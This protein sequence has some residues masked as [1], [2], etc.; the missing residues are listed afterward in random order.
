VAVY[1]CGHGVAALAS[2]WWTC[3][4][5]LV[6]AMGCSLEHRSRAREVVKEC[7]QMIVYVSDSLK[8]VILVLG[9]W[10]EDGKLG[11]LLR[12]RRV[13]VL[14]FKFDGVSVC[15]PVQ[16]LSTVIALPF[17]SYFGGPQSYKS[18]MEPC[19]DWMKR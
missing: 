9:L 13:G 17:G 14:D 19:R 15:C 2:L 3:V 1:S 16:I 10:F 4:L 6:V 7:L 5:G 12:H 18:V 8:I 11:F